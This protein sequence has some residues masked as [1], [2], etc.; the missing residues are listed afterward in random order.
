MKP[1]RTGIPQGLLVSPILFLFFNAPLIKGYKRLGLLVQTGGF[2]DDI[3][4]LAY[5]KS[6]ERNCQILEKAYRECARWAAIYSTTFAP[7]KYNL[8]YL[9]RK[10]KKVNLIATV[11]LGTVS[12]Q[13]DLVIRVLGL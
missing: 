3:H 5:S 11:R 13:L 2:V 12:I 4:L 8:V 10:P 7:A 1:A 6:I 9:T